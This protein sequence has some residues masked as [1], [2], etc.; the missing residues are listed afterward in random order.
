MD[1]VNLARYASSNLD[2]SSHGPAAASAASSAGS[3]QRT[4]SA[5]N[6]LG[7]WSQRCLQ[8]VACSSPVRESQERQQLL[9]ACGWITPAVRQRPR[10]R[11]HRPPRFHTRGRER[12]TRTRPKSQANQTATRRRTEGD[13]FAH[14]PR[15][16]TQSLHELTYE[17]VRQPV[18]H[19][20]HDPQHVD[21]G[22]S[23]QLIR[24]ARPI[25][26]TVNSNQ[27]LAMAIARNLLGQHREPVRRPASRV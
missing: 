24:Y 15:G 7:R 11:L 4:K 5:A 23:S 12:L 8:T 10:I 17:G 19:C 1:Y 9:R 22:L 27:H 2:A 20:R 3:H 18:A 25:R 13:Y 21:K 26:Q 16:K 14:G 6:S